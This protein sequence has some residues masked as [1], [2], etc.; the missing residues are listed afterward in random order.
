MSA[1][2]AAPWPAI[3]ITRLLY[4]VAKVPRQ[5]LSGGVFRGGLSGAFLGCEI[6]TKRPVQLSPAMAF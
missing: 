4:I 2:M 1:S 5:A 6:N 3:D